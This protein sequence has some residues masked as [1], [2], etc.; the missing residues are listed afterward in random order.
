M[1]G[2]IVTILHEYIVCVQPC[3]EKQKQYFIRI[4]IYSYIRVLDGG[5]GVEWE[6]NINN[7]FVKLE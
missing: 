1:Y 7:I 3:G 4:S 5:G 2:C 6:G